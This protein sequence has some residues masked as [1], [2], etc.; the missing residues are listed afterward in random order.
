MGRRVEGRAR[1][2]GGEK[3]GEI[4]FCSTVFYRLSVQV[5]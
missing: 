2:Y 4:P 5:I 1:C 3:D